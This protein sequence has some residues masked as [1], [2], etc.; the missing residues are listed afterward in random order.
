MDSPGDPPDDWLGKGDPTGD[1]SWLGV[2]E[3]P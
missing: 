1:I 2:R 3:D